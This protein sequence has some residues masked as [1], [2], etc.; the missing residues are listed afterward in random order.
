M[1]EAGAEC[2]LLV[3]DDDEDIRK[4]VAF[5]ARRIGFRQVALAE[6]DATS[7]AYLLASAADQVVTTQSGVLGSIGVVVA[8]HDES[9]ANEEMGVRVTEIHAG[10]RKVDCSPNKPLDAEARAALQA[11]VNDFYDLFVSAVARNRGLSE[12]AIRGTQAGLYIGADAV[13]LGLADEVGTLAGTLQ[14]MTGPVFKAG[15]IQAQS[16]KG[17]PMGDRNKPRAGENLAGLLDEAIG[18]MVS[19]EKTKDM[20][21]ADMAEASGYTPE[22]VGQ[23]LS[24]DINCPPVEKLEG[25]AEALGVSVEAQ[26]EAAT[27]DGCEYGMEEA[28]EGEGEGEGAEANTRRPVLLKCPTKGGEA[29]GDLAR[30]QARNAELEASLAKAETREKAAI[31]AKHQKDGRVVP[32]QVPFLQKTAETMTAEDLDKYL[33]TFPVVAHTTPAGH[34]QGGDATIQEDEKAMLKRLGIPVDTY[35]KYGDL[36]K[37]RFNSDGSVLGVQSDGMVRNLEGRA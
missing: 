16:R 36:Q 8:H 3:V 1:T 31:I 11:H 19:E 22:E 9:G 7:A 23:V 12:E 10:D 35:R 26:I 29:M 33:A 14:A 37:I 24:G 30:I 13:A 2:S 34:G 18:A 32:A 4:L 28:G 15:A 17:R 5:V 27:A 21:M 20:V 25:F 6:D